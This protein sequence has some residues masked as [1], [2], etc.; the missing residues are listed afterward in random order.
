[1]GVR[2]TFNDFQLSTRILLIGS[3][4]VGVLLLIGF[5]LTDAGVD[6]TLWGWDPKPAWL[7]RYNADW[8]HSHA[9]IPNI[10]AAI[11]GFLTGAPVALIVLAA[12]TVQREERA[13]L[14]RVNRMTTL[15]WN[16]FRNS[17]LELC[18]DDRIYNGLQHLPNAVN[19]LHDE[20]YAE[21]QRRI[22]ISQTQESVGSAYRGTTDAEVL[23]FQAFLREKAD[24]LEQALAASLQCIGAHHLL[25]IQ[26][27]IIRTNWNTLSQYV[28]LQRLE[29][30][31]EWFEEGLDA[32]LADDLSSNLHP[33]TEF[34]R[35]HELGSESSTG[36]MSAVLESIRL[37][38][39]RPTSEIS[40][41]FMAGY[42]GRGS[43]FVAWNYTNEFG[44]KKVEG[45]QQAMLAA[46][47]ALW[48]IKQVVDAVEKSGWPANSMQPAAAN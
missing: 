38:S 45:H 44:W 5:T 27:S 33:V 43:E 21:Y 29:R 31:L 14:D 23:E 48:G 12:F 34:L 11:T 40:L 2:D 16:K 6:L 4:V 19:R 25:Q 20:I 42:T 22:Q 41:K 9:Y 1:M 13:A 15:A 35:V 37:D 28:R 46:H 17:T 39:T 3:F 7:K 47:T 32:R 10:F 26:W 18:S 24:A 36:S 8:F 30:N